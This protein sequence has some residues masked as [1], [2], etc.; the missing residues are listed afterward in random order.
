MKYVCVYLGANTGNNPSFSN[1]VIVLG[2]EIAD[3][4][5]TLIYGGSS[6]G[7]MGLLAKTVKQNGGNVIG[8]ITKNL[9]EKET[10]S[11]YLDD[12]IVVDSMQER[13]KIMQ[14]KSDLFIVFPGGLGTLEEVFE[15]WNS[16]KIGLIN[17]PI[18]FLNVCNYFHNLFL[19]IKESENNGFISEEYSKKPIIN[20]S[21]S[22]LISNLLNKDALCIEEFL[23]FNKSCL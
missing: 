19:F 23:D 21:P 2:K 14:A 16:I 7:L 17:K 18:G 12:L 1:A 13:K 11:I 22:I 5:L 10:K 9:L 15:T 3:Q 8:I 20:N 4:G 6:L